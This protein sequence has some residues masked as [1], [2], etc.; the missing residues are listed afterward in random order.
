MSVSDIHNEISSSD[1]IKNIIEDL[2][3]Y[4]TI[5]RKYILEYYFFQDAS[6]CSPIMSTD[7]YL[8][9]KTN[10]LPAITTLHFRETECDSGLLKIYKQEDSWTLEV[11]GKLMT[12][13]G[14]ILD[15]A[16]N[17]AQ[18]MSMQSKEIQQIGHD[19][20]IENL[21]KLD[22]YRSDLRVNYLEGIKNWQ[23][24]YNEQDDYTFTPI[25]STG[26]GLLIE[27]NSVY[28]KPDDE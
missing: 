4:D 18:K 26:E 1:I 19:L 21:E 16:V 22:E 2:F 24:C 28:S 17:H 15:S 25:K 3:S 6:L 13:T 11:M 23:E 20:A 14:D 5:K 10:G 12:T 9:G 27:G 8:M 7:G